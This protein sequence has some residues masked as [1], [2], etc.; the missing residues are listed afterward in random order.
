MRCRP[1]PSRGR[2]GGFAAMR[3]CTPPAPRRPWSAPRGKWAGAASPGWSTGSCARSRG[4]PDAARRRRRPRARWTGCRKRSVP[5]RGTPMTISEAL[6]RNGETFDVC[7]VGTGP[8]GLAL[9]RACEG[10][11][12]TVLMLERGGMKPAAGPRSEPPRGWRPPT[13]RCMS[14][15]GRRSAE[16]RG[17]G[18]VSACRS[19]RPTSSGGPGSPGRAGRS[20]SPRSNGTMPPPTPISA[21][22]GRAPPRSRSRR[23]SPGWIRGS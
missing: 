23:A 4:V 12:L 14:R 20:R 9:A 22:P 21:V 6:P 7:V 13:T 15:P 10:E 16:A 8:A 3:A 2:S 19:T 5:W 18:A 11:G 1:R 17:H